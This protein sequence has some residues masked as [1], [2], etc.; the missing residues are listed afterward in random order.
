MS[1]ILKILSAG[2]I[3]AVLFTQA[4][5]CKH[6]GVGLGAFQKAATVALDGKE[7]IDID[8]SLIS[9]FPT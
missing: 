5:V 1:G 9:D 3:Y 4:K 8:G 2:I 6:P 7:V